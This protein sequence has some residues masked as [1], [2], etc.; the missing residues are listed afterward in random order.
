MRPENYLAVQG[1]QCVMLCEATKKCPDFEFPCQKRSFIEQYMFDNYPP[2][3]DKD[4]IVG[5]CL[6][7]TDESRTSFRAMYDY[8]NQFG[9]G[10]GGYDNNKTTHR[11]IDIEKVLHLGIDGI[12][13]EIDDYLAKTDANDRQKVA[14]YET[15]KA[16]LQGVVRFALRYHDALAAMA[17]A[18][19]DAARKSELLN[20]VK[21]FEQIPAKPAQHFYEAIQCMWFIQF[22][23]L[24]VSDIAVNGRP[25]NYLWEYY[26]KDLDSGLITRELALHLIEEVYRRNNDVY[27]TWDASV[28]IGGVDREGNPVWNEVTKMCLEAIETVGMVNPSVGVCYT[29]DIP[30]DILDLCVDKIAKGYTFP[31]LFNDR[32]VQ[33]GLRDAGVTV[34]DARYYQHSTC[35]EITPIGASGIY[36]AMPYINLNRTFD[37]ILNEKKTNYKIGNVGYMGPGYGGDDKE[38]YLAHDV[39]F[40]LDELD[41]F[42]KF[43]ALAKK[44]ASEIIASHCQGAC[45]YASLGKEKS[46][47]LTSALTNDCLAKG[48]DV[49]AGGARY[50]FVYPDFPG[51]INFIDSLNAIKKAVYEDK[52]LT[53]RELAALLKNNFEGD[54]RMHQYLL[55]E[56]PK[57]GN[58][59]KEADKLAAELFDFVKEDLE[60]YETEFGGKF[61][62]GY[63]AWI[64]HGILGEITMA[65]PDGRKAGT[66]LS[67]HIG[68]VQGMD[69]NG[70][71]AT[72]RSTA[73]L[74]QKY[75]IGGIA[76]NYRFSKNFINSPEGKEAVKN[77]IRAFMAKGCFEIQFNVVDQETLKDAQ[78]HPELYQN[79]LIRVAGF[80]EYF[81]NLD[82]VIQDEIMRRTEHDA[83]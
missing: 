65:T 77:F 21:I 55:N 49:G 29:E 35:V 41:T 76:S 45:N 61:F 66:A 33:A 57:F 5:R 15:A 24:L 50:A 11:V 32:I 30:E 6:P 27:G 2:V 64:Y 62:P 16:S 9:P 39:D 71:L 78:E 31:S 23:L 69:R 8:M 7:D 82:K 79:L 58:N 72:M 28:M 67:E 37:F 1:P 36:V 17:E 70:P 48:L 44:V 81:V 14:F 43:Y 13:A 18:E 46:S 68:A 63:F 75:G 3:I 74:N 22:C 54:E 53:L 51:F 52:K 26:K 38:H 59:D 40:Q 10:R 47:P 34:E 25:D 73:I 56:C 12:I 60:K 83:I 20:L 42:D 4:L 80:S 19:T